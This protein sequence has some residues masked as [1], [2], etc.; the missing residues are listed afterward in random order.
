MN[1]NTPSKSELANLLERYKTA[2]RQHRD[3]IY[4]MTYK[5]HGSATFGH[6]DA[7]MVAEYERSRIQLLE[8]ERELDSDRIHRMKR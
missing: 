5:L 1:A 7:K 4:S 6:I 8:V 2:V 3:A